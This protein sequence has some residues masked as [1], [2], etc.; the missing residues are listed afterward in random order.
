MRLTWSSSIAYSFSLTMSSLPEAAIVKGSRIEQALCLQT[1][2]NSETIAQ[3]LPCGLWFLRWWRSASIAGDLLHRR[4]SIGP[5][6]AQRLVGSC[7][8]AARYKS[9]LTSHF[10]FEFRHHACLEDGYL[11]PDLDQYFAKRILTLRLQLAG[12]QGQLARPHLIELAAAL[13]VR[14]C[15]FGIVMPEVNFH[16]RLVMHEDR[17]RWF[18]QHL[19]K[20]L[21]PAG[22]NRINLAR[23]FAVSFVSHRDKPVA[24]EFFQRRIERPVA[25]PI[26][27]A[28]RFLELALQIIA[29]H[30]G[31]HQKAEHRK[32]DID[33]QWSGVALADGLERRRRPFA[34]SIAIRVKGRL[35]RS[36][37]PQLN[38]ST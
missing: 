5:R 36:H 23:A 32:L 8:F 6:R 10:N 27:K 37:M 22:R 20:A 28:D 29:G 3:Q 16:L 24:C 7:G 4:L 35:A 12:N 15:R 34:A 31:I 21:A 11:L 14:E 19:Q 2:L 9:D 26:K 18:R 30:F 17:R 13:H 1:L 33:S 38:S 25:D